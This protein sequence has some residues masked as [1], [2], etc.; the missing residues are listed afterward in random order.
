MQEIKH[1]CERS[2]MSS[3]SWVELAEITSEVSGLQG[4][5]NIARAAQDF[6]LLQTINDD[7]LRATETRD[8][9]LMRIARDIGASASV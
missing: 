4:R 8:A 1:F 3:L 2:V 9:L 5:R 7:L 6:K